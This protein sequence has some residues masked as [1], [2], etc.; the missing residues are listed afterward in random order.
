MSQ[1]RI[2]AIFMRGG[3]SKGVFF[4]AEDVPPM[5]AN[6]DR[7]FLEAIGSPDA[8]GRQLNGMGGGI[9]S[10]SKCVVIGPPS[11]P[12]ADVDYTFGQVAVDS[13]VVDYGANCG[14][15]SS[16]VGPF[17]IDTGRVSVPEGASDHVV[18]IHNTNTSKIIHA[19]VPLAGKT[20]AVLGDFVIPGV[21]GSGARIRLDFLDPGGAV[22]SG[23]LPTG[24]VVDVLDIGDGSGGVEATVIDAAMP[25]VFV[26]AA[27]LG[28]G[29]A[30]PI[31]DIEGN[32]EV[33]DRLE[34]I[35]RAAGVA[36][37]IAESPDAVPLS[38]PKIG[39]VAAPGAWKTIS[40]I[41]MPGSACDLSARVVSMGTIHRVL[42]LTVAMC[43]AV[44]ARIEGSV[45]NRHLSPDTAAMPGDVRLANPS[46]VL[47]VAASA[48]YVAG[49][50]V[51]QSVTV[52][53]TAR[54]LMAGE[55]MVPTDPFHFAGA[56]AV[57]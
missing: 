14:N 57:A 22:T 39:F 10:V 25:C 20:A 34:R 46:G 48:E 37:G 6:R 32:R 21:D 36:M 8:Y 55:V 30:E 52:Y 26:D 1:F 50:W 56:A 47:P 11:R 42:P 13:P 7:L 15:L 51:A 49:A 53:R 41:D 33:M 45:P 9:S 44:A 2:P 5:G 17:A 24:R 27:R 31:A 28:L 54:A 43:L 12:D 19:T 23:L 29:G 40:G 4:H 18:R 38:V 35:R 16:A 3:S